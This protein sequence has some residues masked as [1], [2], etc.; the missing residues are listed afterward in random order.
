MDVQSEID[1]LVAEFAREENIY[2]RHDLQVRIK[3]L[4]ALESDTT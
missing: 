1:K 2:R 3:E 4:R